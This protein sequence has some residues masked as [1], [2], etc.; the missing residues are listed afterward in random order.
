MTEFGS[1]IKNTNLT[2]Y[3]NG[4]NTKLITDYLKSS[5]IQ[6]K[7]ASIVDY[8][9]FDSKEISF[10]INV[11]FIVLKTICKLLLLFGY[12]TI[13]PLPYHE[14]YAH[15]VYIGTS[16]SKSCYDH[17]LK[18]NL[19]G[20]LTMKDVVSTPN[21]IVDFKQFLQYLYPSSKEFNFITFNQDEEELAP[22][23]DFYDNYTLRDSYY[24]AGGGAE[25]SDPSEF[26]E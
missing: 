21:N 6:F 20:A 11:S 18:N 17:C 22:P 12:E 8:Q 23:S 7:Q 1:Q 9:N 19:I 16:Y 25:W 4:R 2:V 24:D 26:W 13:F 3:T 15:G 10:S 14:K 5:S